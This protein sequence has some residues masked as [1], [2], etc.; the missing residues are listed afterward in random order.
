MRKAYAR[1][2]IYFI[3]KL[4]MFHIMFITDLVVF[5]CV[6]SEIVVNKMQYPFGVLSGTVNLI[7]ETYVPCALLI[8]LLSNSNLFAVV[9][10]ILV[11][12]IF[13]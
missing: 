3:R 11:S 1:K 13:I 7:V 6:P 10:S 9:W 4:K 12:V 2:G 5:A 8:S